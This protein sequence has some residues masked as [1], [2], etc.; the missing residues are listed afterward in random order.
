MVWRRYKYSRKKL[1]LSL[2]QEEKKEE[3]HHWTEK[4]QQIVI[5]PKCGPSIRMNTKKK[6]NYQFQIVAYLGYHSQW[7]ALTAITSSKN[8]DEYAC[9]MTFLA[10]KCLTTK[11]T[12]TMTENQ[13]E[14]LAFFSIQQVKKSLFHDIATEKSERDLNRQINATLILW[15]REK[16]RERERAN[17]TLKKKLKSSLQY[18]QY[19]VAGF[20]NGQ[21]V[22]FSVCACIGRCFHS[23]NSYIIY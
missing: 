22:L 21:N 6:R 14:H 23:I 8:K 12:K 7:E 18:R 13:W 15:A 4:N 3:K 10:V 1:L 17:K 19:K 2:F 20:L 16:W 5:E 11:S 9:W